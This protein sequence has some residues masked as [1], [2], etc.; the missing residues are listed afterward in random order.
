[1]TQAAAVA[2]RPAPEEGPRPVLSVC[3]LT[4][5]HAP[6][7]LAATLRL[8]RPLAA[9][10]VVALDDRRAG[11]APELATVADRVL[12]FEHVEPGDRPIAWLVGQCRGGWVFNIDDD[13]IPSVR[14]LARLPGL[15]CDPDVTHCWVARRW[16]YPDLARQ[17]AVPPWS[18]EY[19]LRL[20]VADERFLRFSSV[21][22]RPVECIGPARFVDAPLWHLDTALNSLAQRRRKALAYERERRGMRVHGFSHNTGLYL[23][24]ARDDLEL[25]PVPE[26]DAALVA[27]ICAAPRVAGPPTGAVE[28][29]APGALSR[30]WPGPPFD[31]TLYDAVVE[32]LLPFPRT[33]VAGLQQTVDVRVR[34]HGSCVWRTGE[35]TLAGTWP[36]GAEGLRT[37]LP[38]DVRPGADAVVPVHLV[39]PAAGTHT[40]E[41]DLVHEHVRWFGTPLR[42]AVDVRPRRRVLVTGAVDGIELVL[43]ELA[44]AHMVEPVVAGPLPG[45]EHPTADDLDA[46]LFGPEGRARAGAVARMAALVLWRRRRSPLAQELARCDCVVVAGDGVAGEPPTRERLRLATIALLARSAGVRVVHVAV[47]GAPPARGALDRSLDRARRL[48]GDAVPLERLAVSVG[49]V[50]LDV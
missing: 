11:A 8:L 30:C 16:L 40:V 9:E 45:H 37:Q 41:I 28:R 4:S 2:H 12:L 49:Q 38:A 32:P 14:L 7:R 17:L 23:P 13:E 48:L 39:P 25:A 44:L 42:L 26:P 15:V 47:P 1:M 18:T 29:P 20:F 35:I 22:H 3:T 21:F 36:G 24:E 5:G 6:T 19:Q 33:L 10:I 34:N 43:D 46:Y 31:E 50:E 27:R